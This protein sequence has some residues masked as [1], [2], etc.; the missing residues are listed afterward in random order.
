MDTPAFSVADAHVIQRASGVTPPV[1]VGIV[2]ALFI[3]WLTKDIKL[4]AQ[5][6]LA[7]MILHAIFK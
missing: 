4:T 7:H 6:I 5:I 1:K 2:L 3:Y